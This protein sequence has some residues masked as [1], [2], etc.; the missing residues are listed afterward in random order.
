M[1]DICEYHSKM[2]LS[3]E[4]IP[5]YIIRIMNKDSEISRRTRTR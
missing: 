1:Y 4:K 2:Y 5:T 3:M